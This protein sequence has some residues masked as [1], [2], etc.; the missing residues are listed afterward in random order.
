MKNF[1]MII[2]ASV[3]L[4]AVADEDKKSDVVEVAKTAAEKVAALD[5]DKDGL[6]SIAEAS[7]DKALTAAF[8]KLDAN[9]DGYLSEAELSS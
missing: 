6:V 3:S 8:Q 2:L 4:S 7:K 5:L 9:K 1:L